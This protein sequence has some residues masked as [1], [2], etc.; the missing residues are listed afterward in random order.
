MKTHDIREMAVFRFFEQISNIPRPSKHEEKIVAYIEAFAKERGLPHRKDEVGN[1]VISK[2]ATKGYEDR[3]TIVLQSHVDMVCEKDTDCQHDFLTEGIKI[4]EDDGWLKA[5]GTTLGADNGIGVAM[6]LA[7]L[8]ADDIEHGPIECLF[9]ID[10]ETGLTG[11]MALKTDFFE[12]KTLIN[13]DSEDEREVVIG[14][15]GGCSTTAEF[16]VNT[17]KPEGKTLGLRVKISGLKGG[18]SGSDIHL[19]RG[20]ANIIMARWLQTA[21]DKCGFRLTYIKGGNLRNAIARECVVEGVVPFSERENV[22]VLFNFFSAD[23]QEELSEADPDVELFME[24]TDTAE[25]IFEEK[26][27]RE[28]IGAL[29][30]CPHGVIAMSKELEGLVETSTNLASVEYLDGKIVISTSQRSSSETSKIDIQRRVAKVFE[31]IGARVTCNEGYP[32]WSPNI[33]SQL[34]K[35][36]TKAYTQIYGGNPDIKAIHAGLECGLIL[37]KRPE[38]DMIS[39]GPTMYDVHSPDERLEIASVVRFWDYLKEI[40]RSI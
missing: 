15:A 14:C 32:G 31:K 9:T 27:Q 5:Q 25:D 23:I 19:G 4:V 7:L 26:Q 8:D 39:I 34:L 13:L 37:S 3:Q 22:R 2:S 10:E 33:N 6:E 24:T 36:A 21:T 30:E 16:D 40:L 20:N 29:L 38:M 12:G 18:H 35:T 1:I 11:A 17:T 28:L